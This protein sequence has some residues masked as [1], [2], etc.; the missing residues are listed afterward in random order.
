[1]S[2][3]WYSTFMVLEQTIHDQKFRIKLTYFKC[4]LA[5]LKIF[6]LLKK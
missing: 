2:P 4:D 6:D 1:M 5:Y 3:F